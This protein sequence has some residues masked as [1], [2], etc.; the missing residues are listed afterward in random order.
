MR[1][2]VFTL[3]VLLVP[4]LPAAALIGGLTPRAR[5]LRP[6]PRS[7]PTTELTKPGVF[8]A[9]QPTLTAA[10]PS[11]LA[12]P[13]E[14]AKPLEPAKPRK[15][16]LSEWR[17]LLRLCSQDK[18]LVAFAFV[19]LVLASAGDVVLPQLQARA[20]NLVLVGS[21]PRTQQVLALQHLAG[22]GVATA[23]A[24]G[25]RGFAFWLCGANLVR[26][27]RAKL[28]GSLVRLP[29]SFHDERSTGELASRLQSD[30]IKLGDVLSLNV[31][32]VLR[33][34]LQAG[35][36]LAFVWRLNSRLGLVVLLGVMIRTAVSA[37]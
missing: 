6:R 29:Q 12:K 7:V 35:G 8:R 11:E 9:P 18:L 14:P 23:V 16:T 20:L 25:L 3:V 10:K 36:G 22:V 17:T 27:L 1:V 24:T 33:Q 37:V 13:S 15:A 26:R 5:L 19:M 21:T 28:F 34:L 2:S 4:Y 31:N 30:C 32:I